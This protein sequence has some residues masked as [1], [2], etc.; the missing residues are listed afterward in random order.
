[1]ASTLELAQIQGSPFTSRQKC[2]EWRWHICE[3]I[4]Y[5]IKE[6]AVIP[7]ELNWVWLVA[8]MNIA[9]F[10][11]RCILILSELFG[12]L[13]RIIVIFRRCPRA[14]Q[15]ASMCTKKPCG[16]LRQRSKT[17][18]KDQS[19]IRVCIK[20]WLVQLNTG[21]SW[22]QWIMFE[23]TNV[24]GK[25]H[26]EHH[27]ISW[28]GFC[29]LRI[30]DSWT[31]QVTKPRILLIQACPASWPWP[32]LPLPCLKLAIRAAQRGLGRS[33]KSGKLLWFTEMKYNEIMILLNQIESIGHRSDE[34]ARWGR[35]TNANNTESFWALS[36]FLRALYQVHKDWSQRCQ[37]FF[38]WVPCMNYV[39]MS[40]IFSD[41]RHHD[42][43]PVSSWVKHVCPLA[44][45]MGV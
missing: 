25:M 30:C 33:W 37:D 2:H 12:L 15:S 20:S 29:S 43:S 40:V 18:T 1:M 4:A 19:V 21:T 14:T 17:N 35:L 23:G 7:Q 39:K 5:L 8:Q 27:D 38:N 3:I 13:Q 36:W 34:F 42:E 10:G 44:R 28:S 26:D 6:L 45:N 31:S 41:L 24:E 32:G 11:T 16:Y 9:N 22:F